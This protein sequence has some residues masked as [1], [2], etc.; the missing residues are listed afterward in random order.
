MALDETQK[1]FVRTVFR[2]HA[3]GEVRPIETRDVTTRI[4]QTKLLHDV[5][6]HSFRRSRGERHDRNMRKEFTKLRQLPILRPKVM[7]PLADAM[8][9]VD[10]DQID[11]PLF[12]VSKKAGQ[13]CP[14]R[15]HIQESIFTI[16]QAQ[17]PLRS[18]IRL[19]R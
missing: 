8:R 12:Q 1:L 13:H 11:L 4:T 9:F 10:R 15:R 5:Q 7:A 3:I 18:F 2:Q 19:Q 16:A 14:L 17:H 6:A